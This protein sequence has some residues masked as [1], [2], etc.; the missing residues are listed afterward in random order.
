MVWKEWGDPL[1]S[2]RKGANRLA[3]EYKGKNTAER[4]RALAQPV[5]DELGYFLWDVRFVKEGGTW[6]LR[7]I[8]DKDGG[9]TIED[10]VTMSRRM[11]PLLDEADP[12]PQS[13]CLEVMSPGAERELTRPEHFAL[14]EGCAAVVTLI[15]PRCGEREFAG[16]IA[17]LDKDGAVVLLDEDGN[18]SV[19]PK[20][21]I[22]SVRLIADWDE[23][24]GD[25]AVADRNDEKL[26][27]SQEQGGQ[28]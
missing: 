14:C 27:G 9:V 10:C 24:S 8:L 1:L 13:Y 20:K 15:R 18:R 26:T 2:L 28:S 23:E 25:E 5:A 16:L 11:S 6:Y 21:E 19:F 12:I 4:C 3:T 22:A 7:Y 17:P